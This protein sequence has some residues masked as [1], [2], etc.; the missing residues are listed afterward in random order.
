M[1]FFN[2]VIINNSVSSADFVILLF[3]LFPNNLLGTAL[4]LSFSFFLLLTNHE[5]RKQPLS[6]LQQFF[7]NFS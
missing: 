2:L 4:E 3:R 5:S 1:L 7:K 6:T